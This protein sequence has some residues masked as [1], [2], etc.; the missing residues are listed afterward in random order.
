MARSTSKS[1]TE[2]R[3]KAEEA[4]ATNTIGR[5]RQVP[6]CDC[7]QLSTLRMTH[8]RDDERKTAQLFPEWLQRVRCHA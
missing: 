1:T 3:S 6:S 8:S 5:K 7:C 2:K 4:V